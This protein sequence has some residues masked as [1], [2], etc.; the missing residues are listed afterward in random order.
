MDLAGEV[1]VEL[2]HDVVDVVLVQ[3][4]VGQLEHGAELREGQVAVAADVQLA[5]CP[6]HVLPVTRQL[7][8]GRWG[9][10]MLA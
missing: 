7:G 8:T 10:T 4:H 2:R 5:E 1:A 3:E 9:D 6:P